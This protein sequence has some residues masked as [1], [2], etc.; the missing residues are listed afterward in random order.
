MQE[1]LP[2][3][4]GLWVER[5]RLELESVVAEHGEEGVKYSVCEA[6][7]EAPAEFADD[8]G[9]A[10]WHFYV[11]GKSVQV[12]VGRVDDTDVYI[13]ATW[14]TSLPSARLVITPDIIAERAKT[15]PATG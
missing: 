6:F 12:G 3:A 15:H 9:F 2:F 5:A 14:E 1:K 13:Q 7:A 11:D 4:S 8:G 10:A